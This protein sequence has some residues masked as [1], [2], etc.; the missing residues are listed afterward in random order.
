M[1]VILMKTFMVAI[2]A[3][4]CMGLRDIKNKPIRMV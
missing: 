4:E 2:V 3:L 1:S